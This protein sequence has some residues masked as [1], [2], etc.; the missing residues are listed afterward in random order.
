MAAILAGEAA[1]R[2]VP[3]LKNFHSEV[4]KG[5][6]SQP[7]SLEVKVNPNLK[8]ADA[9]MAEWRRRQSL[10][11]V[12]VPIRADFQTFQKDLS[13]VEHIFERSSLSKAIRIN[14]VVLGLD[15]LPALAYAAGSAASGLD[16]LAKSSLAL[17][18][19]LG[20]ALASAGALA[21]G[22]HGVSDAFKAYK[23]DSD[24][25]A[26]SA[27]KVQDA[28]RDLVSAKRNLTSAIRDQK[29]EIEDL[30][31]E[32]RRSSLNEADAVL[33]IQEDLNRLRQGGFKN[34]TE[35]Q[36]AVLGLLRDEDR[37]GEVRRK[38]SRTIE[39]ATRANQEGVAQSD[40]V[41]Q[42]LDRVAK[43]TEALDESKVSKVS[44]ALEKLSPNA[45]AAVQA[46]HALS[47]EWTKLVQTPTQ[48][49]LFA[50]LDK[51]VANLSKQLPL[52]GSGLSGVAQGLNSDI[53]AIVASLGSGPNASLL[54]RIFG[55][56]QGGLQNASR[57]MDSLVSGLLKLTAGSADF[58]PRLGDAAD[59]VFGK[60]DT[61]VTKIT[62]NG[63]LNKWIDTGLK[64]VDSLGRSIGHI[65]SIID[66]V[67]SAFD[68]A[69]GHT[70][71]F[72]E[73]LDHATGKLS[74]FLSSDEGQNKLTNYFKDAGSFV[75][76]LGHDLEEAKPLFKDIAAA[77][78][79]WGQILFGIIGTLGRLA[80]AIQRNTGLVTP[81][82][83]GYLAFRTVKPIIDG[84]VGSAKAYQKISEA[85]AKQG[86]VG[87]LVS[88]A[89]EDTKTKFTNIGTSAQETSTKVQTAA[90][91][92]V[93][94]EQKVTAA[95]G[96]ADVAIAG[97]AAAGKSGGK[98]GKLG[99]AG[100]A[101]A[102]AA[103]PIG[104]AAILSSLGNQGLE[105]LNDTFKTDLFTKLGEIP[106]S[107][108]W[109]SHILGFARGG[110]VKG[111]GGPTDDANLVAM[112]AGEH[113]TKAKAVDYYGVKLFDDL[114]NMRIP[115]H[116]VGG[117]QPLDTPFIGPRP[118]PPPVPRTTVLPPIGGSAGI[119]APPMAHNF[120]K[121]WYAPSNF[122][123]PVHI[124]PPAPPASPTQ[125]F[126]FGGAGTGG[127]SV[128]RNGVG[129]AAPGALVPF[130]PT[131]RLSDT[132]KFA[133]K[134]SGL[135]SSI[136]SAS[137][138]ADLGSLL[139]AGESAPTPSTGRNFY[140]D[141][142][143][144]K[145]AI[146][147]PHL[148]GSAPGAGSPPPGIDPTIWRAVQNA[149]QR[150]PEGNKRWDPATKSYVDPGPSHLSGSSPG[151][152]TSPAAIPHTQTP[153]TPGAPVAG[154]IPVPAGRTP[155][156][157][158][159]P[160]P[161]GV[162]VIAPSGPVTTQL[163]GVIDS[164]VGTPYVWGG[165]SPAGVDCSGLAA[166][167]ANVATG[168]PAFSGRF[169]TATEGQE[170]ASRGFLPGVGPPGTL[171]IGWKNGGP[172][173][174]HTAVTLPDGTTVSSGENG[175][176]AYGGAGANAPDFTDHMY[177]PVDQG[178][179]NALSNPAALGLPGMPGV[180]GGIPGLG[181][182]G[183]G[184]FGG[185]GG[186]LPKFLQPE[187]LL[188]FFGSQAQSVGSGALQIG[189]Q[190]LQGITGI[191]LSPFLS[192]GQGIANGAIQGFGGDGSGGL[193]GLGGLLG[194]GG[195]A[196]NA[197]AGGDMANY[198]NGQLPLGAGPGT[199]ATILGDPSLGGSGAGG[200][201]GGGAERWRPLVRQ[202]LS[203][204]GPKYG[205][206]A[207]N[208]K[209]WEDAIVKQIGTE[210]GGNP[211]SVNPNDPN[212]QGGTQT[213]GGLLNFLPSTFAANNVTG[214]NFMDPSAQIA[215]AIPYVVQKYGF[216]SSGGPNHI[217]Q[218]VGFA[219]GGFPDGSALVS[220]GEFITNKNA[221]GHYGPALFS[222]LNSMS[223]P[224]K[225]V[226]GFYGKF[227]DGGFTLPIPGLGGPATAPG[228]TPGPL[229]LGGPPGAQAPAPGAADAPPTAGA[230]AGPPPL[231][232]P[233][234]PPAPGA[235]VEQPQI[236]APSSTGGPPG[237]G[238][239]APA[240][241]PGGLP[242][243]A[244][245]LAGLGGGGPGGAGPG[246]PDQPG[247]GPSDGQGDNRATLGS[248]PAS[249][250]H[251]NPALSSGI[252]GAFQTAGSLAA[253]AAQ[254]GITA[255]TMGAGGPAGGA[256]AQGIQAGAQMAGQIA[257]GAVNILSSLLVGTATP[258][259]TASA[260][261]VPLL[262]QRQPM[263]TGV[264]QIQQQVHNGDVNYHLTNLDEFSRTQQRLEAQNV[265]PWVG[266][267]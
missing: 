81:L 123:A 146:G 95:A 26:E 156:Y 59:K 219:S 100:A 119:S 93:V 106:G 199:E 224:K 105:G 72:L 29:R 188:N 24:N 41:Q 34:V 204:V 149:R 114:N 178:A 35:Y 117:F 76:D 138:A 136:S 78:H 181:V 182:P 18:G 22:I 86:G 79:D 247:A 88:T 194:G 189:L 69:S 190:F 27:R 33:S 240:P 3:T 75:K 264:P 143:G 197:I 241:D 122:D 60:F 223:I 252:Q 198:V 121:D 31:A 96:E 235:A 248:R 87:G 158:V 39:D 133:G 250:D 36:R 25:A 227:E 120:Y 14:L 164:L 150:T 261:G 210:S 115:K 170:L 220:R 200:V 229:N 42:A 233:D 110:L 132:D 144:A 127:G 153:V 2:I 49:A 145:P 71:G 191:N 172:Y 175:G 77:A 61:W 205:I 80:D 15:A 44:K 186:F 47:G 11:S 85:I 109:F 13:Q 183:V 62:T 6:R 265:M 234:A 232:T 174:G 207:A 209:L 196:L 53:R 255:G 263:Q 139:G 52:L 67:S 118:A 32:M 21:T 166:V 19:I 66:S 147:T 266:K 258:G 236:A 94:A 57:G 184:G 116:S 151:P 111:V 17:P 43:A 16:A 203:Q 225:A 84:V 28:E 152:A 231:P 126:D 137:R 20:G 108:L 97:G 125:G 259:S 83:E 56:T 140:K 73:N 70:G 212:G 222:A 216:N 180:P 211:N 54:S 257:T 131:G 167:I 98:G 1:V 187:N 112:S 23:Q 113:V 262:P 4:R 30:N 206:T 246:G 237:P 217:G 5:L 244:D 103:G 82:V 130:T 201:A 64:A 254:I 171:T 10:E 101:A 267:Y 46:V 192:A 249:Y 155:V 48:D 202:M 160:G 157:A 92:E 256:A 163:R 176:V 251:T 63:S 128:G 221:V 228:Q 58:L 102:A 159:A 213:V 253:M 141:W 245:A 37:L 243:V 124:P 40:R 173:G 162:P 38:N 169:G 65:V 135:G 134:P 239:S 260:S 104:I 238:A 242:Q 68:K 90:A 208:E 99:G 214:G 215:A 179:L 91:E 230:P 129:P 193:G 74:D 161:G 218:G 89:L 55:D 7:H 51:D 8:E 226:G 9:Q 154:G 142:Y 165:N 45:S 107:G 185:G 148:S 50:G 177:L 12:K 195:S 168:R